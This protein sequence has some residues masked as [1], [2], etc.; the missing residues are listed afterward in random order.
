MFDFKPV[1]LPVFDPCTT[2][3]H[4]Y[5]FFLSP[6]TTQFS[7]PWLFEFA[8]VIVPTLRPPCMP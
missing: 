3:S 4:F 2:H 7:V 6:P 1:F 8:A 5:Y